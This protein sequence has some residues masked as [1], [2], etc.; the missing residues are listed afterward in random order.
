MRRTKASV[1]AEWSLGIS[2]YGAPPDIQNI[3]LPAALEGEGSYLAPRSGLTALR[4]S[5]CPL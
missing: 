5:L 1:V 2:S 4:I 3:I